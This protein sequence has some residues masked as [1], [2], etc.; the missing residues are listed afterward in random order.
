[1]SRRPEDPVV[2]GN[3]AQEHYSR[4]AATYDENWVY[5]PGFVEWMTDCI[6]QRLQITDGDLVADI[7]C[8][9]GLFA[10]GLSPHAAAV[11]CA[12]PSAAM[13][14]QVPSSKRLITVTASAQDI[15]AG[16]A[17]LPHSGYDAMLLKEML[18]H[19][20]DRPAVIA[21]L[22][23][24]LRPGGRMLIVMLPKQISYPLF[25]AALELFTSQQP[26]PADVADEMRGAG[27]AVEVTYESLPLAF[28]A[29]RYLQMV[30][31]RYM[32]LLSYFDDEQLEAGVAEIRRAHPGAEITFTD[33]FA[34]ILGRAA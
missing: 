12:D 6:Q 3:V 30:R 34:F 24:L 13:L 16:R 28:P 8:G 17:A 14:A 10:R 2:D 27:L 1:V 33:T 22:A 21:G 31:N 9:T 7:G 32:S 25:A 20:D 11:V 5:S 29:E 18:H 23:R 19:V 26:D 4:L 15:S